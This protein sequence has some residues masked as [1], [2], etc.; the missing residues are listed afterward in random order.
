MTT[1]LGKTRLFSL[2][3]ILIISI[4]TS[5]QISS[6]QVEGQQQST[7]IPDDKLKEQYNSL[8]SESIVG[9]NIKNIFD[10]F[11]NNIY[12]IIAIIIL[13]I[14]LVWCA[15]IIF[16]KA[17]EGKPYFDWRGRFGGRDSYD[18]AGEGFGFGG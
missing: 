6:K 8:N 1:A 12:I 11:L 10:L 13:F 14:F 2:N 7:F 4:F 5:I 17:D 18:T 16:G 9:I 3:I 15:K